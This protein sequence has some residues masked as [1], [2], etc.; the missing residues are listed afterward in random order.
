VEYNTVKLE[1][2]QVEV[3]N[4]EFVKKKKFFLFLFD[5]ISLFLMNICV[6]LHLSLFIF[7]SCLFV[8]EK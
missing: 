2:Q 5:I 6:T 8:A 4:H 1:N 3:K 7:L